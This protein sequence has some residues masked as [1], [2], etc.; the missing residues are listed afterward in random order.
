MTSQCMQFKVYYSTLLCMSSMRVDKVLCAP[1]MQLSSVNATNDSMLKRGVTNSAYSPVVNIEILYMV[2]IHRELMKDKFW[3]K[4]QG[5]TKI[6]QI[7]VTSFLDY[8]LCT[9]SQTYQ[10]IFSASICNHPPVPLGASYDQFWGL[11][12]STTRV[13]FFCSSGTFS[14]SKFLESFL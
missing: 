4:W 2:I 9:C 6:A 11:D 13:R 14:I 12:N 5:V 3:E 7:F 8:H 10:R 1:I